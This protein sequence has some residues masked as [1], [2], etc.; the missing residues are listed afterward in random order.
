MSWRELGDAIHLSATSAAERVRQL[1]RRGVIRRYRVEVDPASIGR[2]LRAFV[3]V[4]LP[5]STDPDEFECKLR[6]RQEVTLATYVTGRADYTLLVDCDGAEGL[7]T[8]VRWLRTE[9]GA[10]STESKLV[11]RSVK[12]ESQLAA[13]RTVRH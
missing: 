10:A 3:E 6:A 9:A 13:S 11:L 5:S 7:D 2:G 1:E 8:F 4:G 12:L